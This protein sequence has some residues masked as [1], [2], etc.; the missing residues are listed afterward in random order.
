MP[1]INIGKL[2]MTF[3]CFGVRTQTASGGS[4]YDA[5]ITQVRAAPATASGMTTGCDRRA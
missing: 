4:I 5:Y 2:T 3:F 1:L